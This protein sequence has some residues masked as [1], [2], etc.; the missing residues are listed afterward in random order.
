MRSD[1][2]SPFLTPPGQSTDDPSERV[3]RLRQGTVVAWDN[4][5]NTNTIDVGG[6]QLQN[7]PVLN[8]ATYT[9]GQVVTL[10]TWAGTWF[11]LGRITAPGTA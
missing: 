3:L 2:L 8:A 11:V 6:T 4:S 9:A 7:V 10:L 1:D 5:T